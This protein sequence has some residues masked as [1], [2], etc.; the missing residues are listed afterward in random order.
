MFRI[1]I[2]NKVKVQ[3]TLNNQLSLT[4]VK[5]V[6]SVCSL[7]LVILCLNSSN[8]FA[9]STNSLSVTT[10]PSGAQSGVALSVGPSVTVL[11]S[12][13]GSPV[14]GDEVTASISPTASLAGNTATTNSSGVARFNQLT[15]TGAVGNYVLT[16]TDGNSVNSTSFVLAAG[17]VSQL[18][19]TTQPATSATN[20]IALST[21]PVV[22][23]ADSF[24]NTCTSSSNSVTAT[25][26]SGV[27]SLNNQNVSASNGIATF[28]GLSITGKVGTFVIGFQ[29]TGT[30]ITSSSPVNLSYGAATK[31]YLSTQPSPQ[32]STGY[33]F[34]VQ[35]VI[36]VQD[37]GGNVV[38]NYSGFVTATPSGGSLSY[39][40]QSIV[41]GVAI[42]NG[43]QLTGSGGVFTITFS[44][45]SLSSIQSNSISLAGT[46]TQ[47]AIISQPSN[48]GQTG[49]PLSIQPVVQVQDSGGRVAIAA[50]GN[51]VAQISSGP[52][53]ASLSN[54]QAIITNGS[55]AFNGITINGSGGTY[56]LTFSGLG[57]TSLQTVYLT[58][59]G[60]PAQVSIVTQPSLSSIDG[61]A[62]LTQ[63]VIAITDSG[64][65]IDIGY[66][67]LV[68]A[69]IQSGKGALLNSTATAVNGTAN[70]SNL[71]ITGLVGIYTLT[72]STGNLTAAQSTQIMLTLGQPAL[73][74][75]T[76]NPSLNATS[77]FPLTTQPV[78]Q[79]ADIGGN[80]TP[81]AS[82][83]VTVSSQ[84]AGITVTNGTATII[85]GKALFTG[86]TFTG[87][88]GVIQATF[89]SGSLSPL[90]VSSVTLAGAATQLVLVT[91]PS[92]SANQ[93]QYLSTQPVL[94]VEDSGGRLVTAA[95]GT[96]TVSI[97]DNGGNVSN[98]SAPIVN[99][100]AS[101][102]QLAVSQASGLTTLQFTTLGLPSVAYTLVIAKLPSP[103]SIVFLGNSVNLSNSQK[104]QLRQLASKLEIGASVTVTGYAYRNSKIALQRAR[105]VGAY[106]ST[107]KQ[108]FPLY[109]SITTKQ[110]SR[111][112]ITVT[113]Q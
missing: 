68:T 92:S 28:N 90:S 20:G 83:T 107:Y 109:L 56:T 73:I 71:T 35:P 111:V 101:F 110:T 100:T 76:V 87:N 64:G 60:P 50:S 62:L 17:P 93:G 49:I 8:A 19:I 21:Q 75:A 98:N 102:T 57:I 53:G 81:T 46:P 25:L 106:I 91:P 32:A 69:T 4:R 65:R 42:F 72:F 7:I 47:I 78:L 103:V 66:T 54:N 88:P 40:S 85:G 2:S 86:L 33:P 1:I 70:F 27:G 61:V 67:G 36:Q 34:A 13:G 16:F 22:K 41:S 105:A 94:S 29:T 99:G 97:T 43:L 108:I 96:V 6:L 95:T 84:T 104:A 15:I 30:S 82:G 51:I 24:G 9:S 37:S 74:V 59:A 3:L 5:S 38:A 31:L 12:P 26:V 112:D 79:I 48:Q 45:G 14:V 113:A 63:P 52:P 10:Q 77:G 89:S 39:T 55:A 11:S 44:S 80:F 23:L 18:I 58:I